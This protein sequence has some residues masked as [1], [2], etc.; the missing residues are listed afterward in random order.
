M[1]TEA[2]TCWKV[3]SK[4][5]QEGMSRNLQGDH[6]NGVIRYSESSHWDSSRASCTFEK[7]QPYIVGPIKKYC[8]MERHSTSTVI[9]YADLASALDE[10]LT[11]EIVRFSAEW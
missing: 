4:P 10:N 2:L 11:Q 9:A 1:A 6:Q 7:G 5:K 8:E 3:P